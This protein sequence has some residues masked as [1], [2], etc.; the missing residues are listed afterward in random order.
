MKSECLFR[1][2][3]VP[4][5]EIIWLVSLCLGP[6]LLVYEFNTNKMIIFIIIIKIIRFS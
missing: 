3:N 6:I 5:L 4:V 1:W 2:D